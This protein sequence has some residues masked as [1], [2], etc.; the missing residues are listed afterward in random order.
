MS[1]SWV[2]STMVLPARCN[3]SKIAMIS[4]PVFESR[5]PVGSS[6]SSSDGW[7]TR[8]RAIATRC[9]CPPDSSFGRWPIRSSSSTSSSAATARSF[10]RA[11][12]TP[13]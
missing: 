8:A 11:A 9:R 5:F 7:F 12:G 3:P 1:A 2:I 13:P 10:R 6:A 4:R